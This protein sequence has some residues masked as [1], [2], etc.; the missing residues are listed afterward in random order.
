[1]P[2]TRDQLRREAERLLSRAS[3]VRSEA[4]PTPSLDPQTTALMV[5]RA[6]VYATLA[7]TAGDEIVT[8]YVHDDHEVAFEST[9]AACAAEAEASAIARFKAMCHIVGAHIAEGLDSEDRQLR[10][11]LTG[12]AY[13]LDRA[14]LGVTDVVEATALKYCYNRHRVRVDGAMYSLDSQWVDALGV[15]WEYVGEWDAHRG[16]I[17]CTP[18][19]CPGLPL[20]PLPQLVLNRGPLRCGQ[21]TPYRSYDEGWGRGPTFDPETKIYDGRGIEGRYDLSLPIVDKDGA[22]W[23]WTGEFDRSE[24]LVR[25]DGDD[26]HVTILNAIE[27]FNGPLRQLEAEDGVE[28]PVGV[29]D[30]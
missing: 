30:V 15:T 24:P 22:T 9:C 10:D 29:P 19:V 7:A 4:D 17:M 5:A 25:L 3:F 14:G 18:E 12:L 2:L 1:M 6:Q 21:S 13:E 26:G 8:A 28:T 20:T 11:F 16:P 23:R 27:V